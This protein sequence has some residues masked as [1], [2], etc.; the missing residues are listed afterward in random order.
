[1]KVALVVRRL[2][3]QGGT[4][5]FTHGFARWLL[6]AGHRVTVWCAG[7][8]SPIDGLEVQ[9]LAATGRGRLWRMWSLARAGSRI[10][11][12]D[13]DAVLRLIRAPGPGVYRAGG[14]CH[15]AWMQSQRWSVADAVAER[16]DRSTVAAA[17]TVVVNSRMAGEDLVRLYGTDP[18]RISLVRNGV[19]LSRFRPRPEARLPVPAGVVFLGSGFARKG[20]QTAIEALVHLPAEHL[21]VYGHDRRSA[22]YQR[23]AHRSGVADR[24]HFMGAVTRPEQVLP[25]ARAL[26]LPTR[27]DPFANACLEAMACGVPVVTTRANGAAEVLPHEW[28]ATAD[29]GDA[30]ALAGVL[31]RVLEDPSLGAACR[32]EAE[33]YPAAKAYAELAEILEASGR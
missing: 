23:Q 9:E 7:V 21:V 5:R 14:G 29:P 16:F 33:R 17:S 10:P 20:L 6:E 3:T 31:Q 15:R 19:D 25:A 1:V 8:D 18:S 11:T 32:A 28:M 24:V 30:P 27:Y 12:E 2:S 13:Y 26:V 4:E 22:T